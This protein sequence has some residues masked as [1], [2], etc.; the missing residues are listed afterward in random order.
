M[1]SQ[2]FSFVPVTARIHVVYS[3]R[4]LVRITMFYGGVCVHGE[5]MQIKVDCSTLFNFYHV[6][7]MVS[8]HKQIKVT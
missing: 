7:I 3:E 5:R 4:R 6:I 2:V 8:Q 1:S